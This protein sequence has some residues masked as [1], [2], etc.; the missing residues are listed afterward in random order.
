M[1]LK[2]SG[3]VYNLTT[4]DGQGGVV[5]SLTTDI[6]TVPEVTIGGTPMLV[7]QADGEASLLI[8]AQDGSWQQI[9]HQMSLPR[10]PRHI[11]WALNR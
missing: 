7:V 4:S 3:H 1:M 9:V 5:E 10:A 8:T 6:V 2:T 11:T